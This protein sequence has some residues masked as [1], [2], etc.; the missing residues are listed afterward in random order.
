[1]LDNIS[2]PKNVKLISILHF[3]GAF[4]SFIII[5]GL[6]NVGLEIVYKVIFNEPT[7]DLN[8]YNSMQQFIIY[9]A[10]SF[11]LPMLAMALYWKYAM[12]K[13]LNQLLFGLNFNLK[14]TLWGILFGLVSIVIGFVVLGSMDLITIEKIV[15]SWPDLIWLLLFF[16]LV[17]IIE[18]TLVRGLL[19]GSLEIGFSKITSLLVTAFVFAFLHI[20]NDHIHYVSLLN[21]FLAGIFLGYSRLYTPLLYFPIGLHLAWNYIQ[22]PVLG[23]AVSGNKTY[24]MVLQSQV[25]A[26]ILTGGQFGFEGSIIASI[27]MLVAIVGV[28]FY[29][30]KTNTQ[31]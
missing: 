16:L 8:P 26:P 24:Q 11:V 29:F 1:M 13:P 23:F 6:A 30:S 18:E 17:A 12:K 31:Q 2:A 14:Q 3:L 21:I 10:G 5:S 20:F 25:D 28:H 9:F 27:V 15:V 22:G 7:L 19:F 4:F